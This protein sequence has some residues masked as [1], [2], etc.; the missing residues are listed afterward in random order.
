M[1]VVGVGHALAHERRDHVQA[2]LLTEAAQRR[3]GLLAD[4][5]VPG[6]DDRALARLEELGGAV[7]LGRDRLDERRRPARHRRAP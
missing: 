3:R 5:A 7:E 2:G 4:D 6:E 1:G